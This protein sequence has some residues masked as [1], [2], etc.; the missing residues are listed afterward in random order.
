MFKATVA[1]WWPWCLEHEGNS[2]RMVALVSITAERMANV[3]SPL[4]VLCFWK[5][6]LVFVL[7][8][9]SKWLYLLACRWTHSWLLEHRIVCK[10]SSCLSPLAK[11]IA[12]TTCIA[13]WKVVAKE[14]AEESQRYMVWRLS[15]LIF[16]LYSTSWHN[17]VFLFP[18][19]STYTFLF[20][21]EIFL[22]VSIQM[23]APFQSLIGY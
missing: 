1:I 19:P 20:S 7:S 2:N 4:D 12:P 21:Y 14:N 8:R 9:L 6:F 18:R 5:E 15:Y 10:W 16:D 17:S 22:Y 11:H 3:L 13:M 23:S